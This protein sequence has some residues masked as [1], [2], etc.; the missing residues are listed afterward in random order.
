MPI[1]LQECRH[2][3]VSQ[4]IEAGIPVEKVSKFVGHASI[5]ITIDRYAHLLPRGEDEAL[6]LLDAYHDRCQR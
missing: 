6:A 5:T 2:S 4:M 1:G 3:A